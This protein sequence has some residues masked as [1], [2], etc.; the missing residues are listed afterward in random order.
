VDFQTLAGILPLIFSVQ[1]PADTTLVVNDPNGNW[2]CND[3]TDGLNPEV[4]ID[5]PI[6][7]RYD[8]WVGTYNTGALEPATLQISYGLGAKLP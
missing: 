5:G 4:R 2:L 6:A 7:G 8:V 1:S 3:D